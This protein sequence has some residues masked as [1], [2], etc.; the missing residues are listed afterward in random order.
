MTNATEAPAAVPGEC[1]CTSYKDHCAYCRALEARVAAEGRETPQRRQARKV[2]TPTDVPA[3]PPLLLTPAETAH[4][5]GIGI[6][7][8][9][10][11]VEDG[12][13]PQPVRLGRKLV[14]WNRAV[15]LAW[16]ERMTRG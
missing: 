7:T 14:R 16:V 3:P 1:T 13:F 15:V 12:R 5:L 10:R 6:R 4:L 11:M 8:L 2:A 9:W